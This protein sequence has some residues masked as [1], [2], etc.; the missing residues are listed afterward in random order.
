MFQSSEPPRY[1]GYGRH[2]AVI[3]TKPQ[4]R[5]APARTAAQSKLGFFLIASLRLARALVPLASTACGAI[6]MLATES[7][8]RWQSCYKWEKEEMFMQ[9]GM[10]VAVWK[11]KSDST[12]KKSIVGRGRK[13][14]LLLP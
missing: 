12:I 8:P 3:L 2:V 10:N 9:M 14:G 6:C 1:G 13:A 7:S 11:A 4:K 5:R